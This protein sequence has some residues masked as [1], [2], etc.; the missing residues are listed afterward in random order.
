[1]R[2]APFPLGFLLLAIPLP[3][4]LLAYVITTLQSASANVTE[5][6]TWKI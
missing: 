5:S 4:I 2:V 1:M 6:S 3:D